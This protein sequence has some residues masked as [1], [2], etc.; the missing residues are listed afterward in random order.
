Q[1]IKRRYPITWPVS[2]GALLSWASTF[3]FVSLGWIFFRAH[4]LEQALAMF[5]TAFLPSHYSQFA[6]P[7]AFYILIPIMA[8]GYFI[9]NHMASFLLAWSARYGKA[10]RKSRE[11]GIPLRPMGSLVG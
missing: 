9:C 3:C 7:I 11:L 4:D 10:F 8:I 5:R 1:R 2:L 6:L